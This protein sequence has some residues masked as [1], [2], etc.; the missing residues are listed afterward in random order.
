MSDL[1]E[2]ANERPLFTVNEAE[3]ATGM[4][5]ASLHEK[6]SRLTQ[7]GDLKRIERGKYTVHN[8]AMIY[9]TYIE[10]PSFLSLWSGLR[11]YDLTTQQPATVQVIT[12]KNRDD[13]PNINFYYSNEMFGFGKKHYQGF[14]IFVADRERLLLDCLGRKQVPVSELGDLVS[15]VDCNT[16]T[17]YAQ[18]LGKQSVKKRLG[19]LLEHIRGDSVDALRVRDR[20][21][22]VLDLTQP[23]EGETDTRWRLRV[24]T[25]VN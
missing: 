25:D 22:P 24:N 11:F 18:R 20:N 8:D 3:R 6:L 1:L 17:E 7:R 16:A 23:A 19:Y 15:A 9:A 10:T 21:Y 4:N 12:P 2:W 13:L 14:Q 5:R